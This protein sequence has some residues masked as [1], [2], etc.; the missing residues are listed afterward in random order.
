MA[1]NAARGWEDTIGQ[2]KYLGRAQELK[3]T[4]MRSVYDNTSEHG[5]T[6]VVVLPH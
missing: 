3:N 5:K 4:H 6:N 1:L 2:N